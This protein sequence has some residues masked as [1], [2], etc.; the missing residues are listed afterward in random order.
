MDIVSEVAQYIANAGYGVLGTDIFAGQIPA[1]TNGIWVEY[2]G[3]GYNNYLPLTTSIV[4][5]YIKNTSASDAVTTIN[6]IK[7]YLHRMYSTTL[8]NAYIYSILVIGGVE[9]VQ[10]DAQYAKVFKISLSIINRD[11]TI[12]S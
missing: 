12:I 4:D 10:R 5:V 8:D 2:S 7:N 6:S 11:T 3:A 1:D 9:S